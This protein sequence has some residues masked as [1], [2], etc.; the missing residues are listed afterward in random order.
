L[1]QY[2]VAPLVISPDYPDQNFPAALTLDD[3]FTGGGV[4][5]TPPSG[6]QING[7]NQCTAAPAYPGS[8]SAIG[9]SSSANTG[10]MTTQAGKY[11]TDYQG[12]PITPPAYAETPASTANLGLP[13]P[14]TILRQT[15]L[16][17]AT[18]DAVMQDIEDS[19]DVVLTGPATGAQVFN[20]APAMASGNP[21]TI[22]VNGDLTL[23]G[24]FGPTQTGN[25]LLLV[26]GTLTY[27]PSASWNGLILVVGKGQ[28]LLG[29]NRGTGGINGA[30]FV[31]QTRD[32]A[33]NLLPTLQASFTTSG[34]SAL[35]SGIAYN[36][37]WVKT[38]QGPLTYK[39]LS[40]H[41][42]PLPN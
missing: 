8:L 16:S 3:G 20:A 25:G 9:Y 18:L 37:C 7:K 15:W 19:A 24:S 21:M 1:L 6:F 38:A 12:A 22:V 10:Y 40:F 30:V 17:P 4:T 39:V 34:G 36:S 23:N 27:H 32:A 31:A 41:E 33:G 26:T 5:F 2:I 14:N 13:L 28:F 35:G 29:G 11:P 42:I